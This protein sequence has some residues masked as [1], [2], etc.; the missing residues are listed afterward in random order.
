MVGVIE[1]LRK[2]K[3][4][5]DSTVCGKCPLDGDM[6]FKNVAD[7]EDEDELV[8]VVMA[9]EIKEGNDAERI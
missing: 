9:Y 2:A 8:K 6:C 3:K 5:C 4:I 1:F 7:I